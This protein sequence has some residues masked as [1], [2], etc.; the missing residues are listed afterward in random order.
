M[1]FTEGSFLELENRTNRRL[2][3]GLFPPPV[4]ILPKPK[5]ASKARWVANARHQP[6]MD[7][8]KAFTGIP[9]LTH[10]WN[11]YDL[12]TEVV[13]KV[14]GR[15]RV[16]GAPTESVSRP[17]STPQPFPQTLFL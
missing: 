13:Q 12:R 17:E 15:Q 2:D 8:I 16:F 6:E 1:A 3:P 5:A 4:L 11:D 7:F 9:N 14:L 10:A